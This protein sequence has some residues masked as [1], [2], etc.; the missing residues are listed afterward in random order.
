MGVNHINL[1]GYI[2]RGPEHRMTP[3]GVPTTNFTVAVTRPPRTEG[4]P[5]VT[6]TIK[7]VAWRALAEKL[8]ESLKKGDLVTIEGRLTSRSYETQDGQ[9]RKAV[10]V[11][12]HG[13]EAVAGAARQVVSDSAEGEAESSYEPPAP[14][15]APVAARPAPVVAEDLDD[16]IP[17]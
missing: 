16:E 13:V 11:E 7:V 15:K 8:A 2:T 14:R 3:N 1:M 4:G 5:E 10:E 17:F 12:A 9:R 6:D